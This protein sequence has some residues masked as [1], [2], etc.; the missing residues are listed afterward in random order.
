MQHADNYLNQ[1]EALLDRIEDRITAKVQPVLEA[2]LEK[3]VD[4]DEEQTAER[5]AALTPLNDTLQSTIGEQIF[6]HQRE[7]AELVVQFYPGIPNRMLTPVEWMDTIAM[8]GFTL[9]QW[10]TR[11]SPSRW[12]RDILKATPADIRQT[13]KTAIQH[14][15][16]TSAARTE[17]FSWQSS[18]MLMWITRPELSA[19]GTCSVCSPLDGRKEKRRKDF[20]VPYPAHP[21]CKCGIVPVPG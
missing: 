3:I 7:I 14:A 6:M 19:T 2:A 16:W 12:M 15:V 11:K 9:N 5:E 21:R 18:P 20:G 4:L 8:R 1:K 10:F 13:V 17:V